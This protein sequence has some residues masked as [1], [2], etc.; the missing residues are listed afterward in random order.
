MITIELNCIS[1]DNIDELNW[2][3]SSKIIID[4]LNWIKLNCIILCV[5]NWIKWNNIDD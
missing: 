5:F 4:D 3:K 2:I 1:S